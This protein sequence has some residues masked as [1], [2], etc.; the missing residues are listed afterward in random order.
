L[1]T[2]QLGC[3][4]QPWVGHG[5]L[6]RGSC[7]WCK[8]CAQCTAI[9]AHTRM[10]GSSLRGCK[11]HDVYSQ[12]TGWYGEIR[13]LCYSGS[14]T[15]M[16]VKSGRQAYS[17]G[18]DLCLRTCCAMH[19]CLITMPTAVTCRDKSIDVCTRRG[20]LTTKALHGSTEQNHWLVCGA[21]PCGHNHHPSTWWVLHWH[22]P[23]P[24]AFCSCWPTDW[25]GGAWALLPWWSG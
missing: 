6:C 10:H 16:G 5:S 12:F 3:R 2:I 20:M 11:L 21:T 9:Q 7:C 25:S 19:T 4:S 17:T 1:H 22:Q 15:A 23:L 13:L 18:T 8:G 24:A 14:Q